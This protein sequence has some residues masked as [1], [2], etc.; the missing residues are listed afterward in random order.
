MVDR[1][2]ENREAQR[3][4]E[5]RRLN[6]QNKAKQKEASDQF[7]KVISGQQESA[8]Q[9]TQQ[10]QARRQ[11]D[12]GKPA[13]PSN[14]GGAQNALLAKQGIKSRNLAEQLHQRGEASVD[15]SR[16]DL[17]GRRDDVHER[18]TASNDKQAKTDNE[19]VSKQQDRLAPIS[20]DDRREQGG[21]GLGGGD[22]QGGDSSMDFG[23]Q[24]QTAAPLGAAD[25]GKS[26]P[27]E[28]PHAPR[29]PPEVIRALVDKVFAGVTPEGLSQ[30]TIEFKGDVLGGARLDVTAKDGK[31][32]CTFHTDDKNIG[33]LLKASE[34]Q[35][36]RTFA[37]KGLTLERLAVEER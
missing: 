18:A 24:P 23:G 22:S 10:E 9:R 32:T 30:F 25:L 15:K 20:R 34:G 7:Q 26:A 14:K 8:R 3:A 27:T 33:R 37:Q 5:E 36:A 4:Q 35:L 13:A 19:V 17:K 16:R 12:R 29:I 11:G 2:D 21:G 28:G 1:I 6:N 31:I